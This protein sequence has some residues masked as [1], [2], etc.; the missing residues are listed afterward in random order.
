MVPKI[1]LAGL[2]VVTTMATEPAVT[3][4]VVQGPP[5]ADMEAIYSSADFL[6]Q[7]SLR[8]WSGLAIMEA[9]SCGCIPVVTDIPSFR[10]LTASGRYGRLYP[11]GDDGA[12]AEALLAIDNAERESLAKS[13]R[14]YFAAELSFAALARQLDAVYDDL[15]AAANTQVD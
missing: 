10:A 11:I 1:N 7:A 8:E 15:V 14:G 3:L 2:A 4:G 13:I 12:L 9:L 6:L 5:L